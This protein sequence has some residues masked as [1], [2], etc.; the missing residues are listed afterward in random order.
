MRN[1]I[2]RSAYEVTRQAAMPDAREELGTHLH[3]RCGRPRG[4]PCHLDQVPP[5]ARALDAQPLLSHSLPQR[6]I[7]ASEVH[8]RWSHRAARQPGAE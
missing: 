6:P 2:G 5:A 8:F 3:V 1:A 7:R 4:Q